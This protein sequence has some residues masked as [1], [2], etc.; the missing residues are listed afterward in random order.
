ML[1][2]ILCLIIIPG[3]KFPM[4]CDVWVQ[5]FE[6]CCIDLKLVQLQKVYAAIVDEVS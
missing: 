3:L 6:K 4:L 1:E 2:S 5:Y